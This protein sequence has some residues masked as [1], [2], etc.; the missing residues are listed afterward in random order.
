MTLPALAFCILICAI[1]VAC[2]AAPSSIMDVMVRNSARL[3][4]YGASFRIVL[5]IALVLAAPES[6]APE[7]VNIV[8]IVAILAGLTLLFVGQTHFRK[9]IDWVVE[10]GPRFVQLWGFVGVVLG[11]VL[12]YAVIP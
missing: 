11:L 6:R 9:M 10:R 12:G 1:G 4:H 7:V 3:P 5:G 2:I 8:G